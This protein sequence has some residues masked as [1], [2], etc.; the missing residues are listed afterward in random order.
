M[1]RSSGSVRRRRHRNT[2]GASRSRRPGRRPI[3]ARVRRGQRAPLSAGGLTASPSST[4]ARSEAA[5]VSVRTVGTPWWPSRRRRP[6]RH[7]ARGLVG[8]GTDTGTARRCGNYGSS[9]TLGS[10]AHSPIATGCRD[11][12]N[13][14]P[15][16]ESDSLRPGAAQAQLAR[17]LIRLVIRVGG[18]HS[19]VRTASR[20]RGSHGS[21]ARRNAAGCPS[22]AGTMMVRSPS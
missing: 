8:L 5:F 9:C 15:E 14:R 12:Q 10:S 21:S 7:A 11:C 19:K 22:G 2:V 6:P 18:A 1:S 13:R 4:I 16:G 17:V 3:E 20:S